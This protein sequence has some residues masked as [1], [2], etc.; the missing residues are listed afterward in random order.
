MNLFDTIYLDLIQEKRKNP[1]LNPKIHI[2]D[3]FEKYKD[4]PD[5]YISYIDA[6]KG[7]P[8]IGINPTSHFN[9]P[10]GVYTY[11]LNQIYYSRHSIKTSP[12]DVPFGGNRPY[13][14]VLR[15]KPGTKFVDNMY[16]D[17]DS[18]DYDNDIKKLK[19]Y[20]IKKTAIFDDETFSKIQNWVDE[21]IDIKSPIRYIWLLT[22]VLAFVLESPI[23]KE[24]IINLV[25]NINALGTDR[26]KGQLNVTSLKWNRILNKV[27]GYDGFADKLGK[28]L[29]HKSEPIQAVFLTPVSYEIIGI[30][31]NVKELEKELKIKLQ[32]KSYKT[33]LKQLKNDSINSQTI[34]TLLLKTKPDKLIGI[35]KE[36][37]HAIN[38]LSDEDFQKAML[39]STNIPLLSKLFIEHKNLTDSNIYDIIKYHP[40]KME[41]INLLGEKKISNLNEYHFSNVLSILRGIGADIKIFDL[42]VE[43]RG[44]LNPIDIHN[45]LIS[46]PD[47]NKI[48]EILGPEN[49][50][51]ISTG[52]IYRILEYA[53]DNKNYQL[54]NIII[55]YRT[56]IVANDVENLLSLSPTPYETAKRLGVKS[57]SKLHDS[58]VIELLK[59]PNSNIIELLEEPSSGIMSDII[60]NYKKPLT[61]SN[62]AALL[63]YPINIDYNKREEI[64]KK[65]GSENLQKIKTEDFDWMMSRAFSKNTLYNLLKQYKPKLT[66]DDIFYMMKYATD[67]YETAMILGSEN[68]SKLNDVMVTLLLSFQS[69]TSILTDVLLKFKKKLTSDN[70]VNLIYYSHDRYERVRTLGKENISKLSDLD[71]TRVFELEP[72]YQ[73]KEATKLLIEYKGKL[74]RKNVFDLLF[75]SF[76]EEET[77]EYLG[78]ENL[79]KLTLEDIA[80]LIK[81]DNTGGLTKGIIKYRPELKNFILNKNPLPTNESF[82][83]FE[84]IYFDLIQ[85]RRRNPEMNPKVHVTDIFKKYKD[86]PDIYISYI[87][88]Y[89]GAAK[90]GINPTSHFNTPLGVYTYPLKEINYLHNLEVYQDDV[91][92]AGDRPYI[93]VLRKKPGIKFV[94]DM[95]TKYGLKDYETDFEKLKEYFVKKTN[96][97]DESTFLKIEKWVQENSDIKSSIR[98]MW[99]LTRILAYLNI[100]PDQLQNIINSETKID[101][102]GKDKMAGKLNETSLKWNRILNKILGYDGFADKS[103]KGLIHGSESTQAVFLTPVSYEIIGIYENRNKHS[104]E[105]NKSLEA[106]NYKMA[107]NQVKREGTTSAAIFEI[108]SRTSSKNLD[109]VLKKIGRKVNLLTDSDFSRII[110]RSIDKEKMCKLLVDYKDKLTPDNMSTI[111]KHCPDKLDALKIIGDERLSKLTDTEFMAILDELVHYDSSTEAFDFLIKTKKTFSDNNVYY[112]LLVYPDTQKIVKFLGRE[113]I[114]SLP[115][116][117]LSKLLSFASIRQKDVLF[118][119]LR[120]NKE[121]NSNEDIF[122]LLVMSQN[123]NETIAE[124]G[125][126]S[127]SKLS[128]NA[129]GN[130]LIHSKN[131]EAI[132][133]IIIKYRNPI[134][135]KDIIYLILYSHDFEQTVKKMGTGLIKKID[136][137]DFNELL[138]QVFYNKDKLCSVL[139]QYKKNITDFN[140]FSILKNL[141]DIG[142]NVVIELLGSEN[143]SKLNDENVR[144]LFEYYDEI[145][146]DVSEILLAYKKPLTP[147]NIYTLLRY[148]NNV[149]NTLKHIPQEYISN[150]PEVEFKTIIS[151][152][153]ICE[154]PEALD[155]L[156]NY[157]KNLTRLN[158]FDLFRLALDKVHLVHTL[159]AE[160]LKKL[161]LNDVANLINT[162]R[163]PFDGTREMLKYRPDIK[164]NMINDYPVL[165]NENYNMFFDFYD[166]IIN[167]SEF[168]IND[169]NA[170]KIYN[171]FANEY[172]QA[173]GQTWDKNKFLSRAQNWTFYGSEDGFVAVRYQKSGLVKLVGV[174]GSNIGKYKGIKELLAKKLPVWGMVSDEL[175]TMAKKI[176][177]IRPPAFLIKQLIKLVPKSVFGGVEFS[178]N[179][180]GSVTLQYGDVGEVK[181]YFIGT[182]EYFIFILKSGVVK[183]PFGLMTLIKKTIGK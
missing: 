82:N 159:G 44:I 14:A 71:F 7:A 109:G 73:S 49:I 33:A 92:F 36:I 169:I 22:R 138:S 124:L 103:G 26:N 1:E 115:K 67:L 58:N 79:K 99:L 179:S 157:K 102:I 46:Y 128:S 170:E 144:T 18:S 155:L 29:I 4:D 52:G 167:E 96:T 110:H 117:Y 84:G 72:F 15:K 80:K 177:F 182:K 6:Y 21:N 175:A 168:L 70:I 94:E 76:Y 108:L 111:I 24:N 53:K 113:R 2:T 77:I 176:G 126:E 141:N 93:A 163:Y 107:L 61:S 83:I 31:E 161:T 98:F 86:D 116:D 25:Y 13:I 148:S 173:T 40:N 42:L 174:A 142:K 133:H 139:L 41:A 131:H 35:F 54:F 43:Y 51:K 45:L 104:E 37:G 152:R 114:L 90:I 127:I 181:K 11:P 48:G 38:M 150:I 55:K 143:I 160:N 3:V 50:N 81:V 164:Q 32:S 166:E 91:P 19:E 145:R 27:L 68:I 146:D 130:L 60:L 57:I 28:G 65:I 137:E 120:S 69:N 134:L 147:D 87:N 112:L 97:Y 119:I 63:I 171:I 122:H 39:G 88:E 106:R 123:P 74:T 162:E 5:V 89:K 85:E 132:E 62:I 129:I 20:F 10:L 154:R 23:R 149:I 140:V 136:D 156:I 16:T 151:M 30:Y 34:L 95:F 172:K 121:L 118:E 9:T 56:N 12:G 183:L 101:I 125:A 78:V 66:S 105:Y 100:H 59:E 8:K 165:A 17:Y 180:D 158:V 135:S 47:T 178:I 153:S 75:H 64:I